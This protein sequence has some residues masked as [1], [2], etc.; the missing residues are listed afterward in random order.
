MAHLFPHL[1]T[2]LASQGCPPFSREGAAA[3][4]WAAG[5]TSA[6]SENAADSAFRA[7]PPP[8]P[9]CISPSPPFRCICSEMCGL[10]RY[11]VPCKPEIFAMCISHV[12]SEGDRA[13]AFPPPGS[14]WWKTQH[15]A[16]SSPHHGPLL[17]CPFLGA[18][19]MVP[20]S[21]LEVPG[22]CS[23]LGFPLEIGLDPARQN[24]KLCPSGFP[25][26]AHFLPV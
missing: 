18:K 16:P 17:C 25:F 12:E 22:L 19:E 24:S 23:A 8:A 20:C 14:L 11:R 13:G 2:H 9:S 7:Q 21:L 5:A 6:P 3:G 26:K 1:L 10:C 4:R 15:L